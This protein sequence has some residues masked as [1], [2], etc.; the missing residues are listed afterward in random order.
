MSILSFLR[1]IQGI[2]SRGGKPA[3]PRNRRLELEPLEWRAVLTVLET[4]LP[5]LDSPEV[6]STVLESPP[7][8][9]PPPSPEDDGG[10]GSGTGEPDPGQAPDP[11]GESLPMDGGSGG[12]NGDPPPDPPLTSGSGSG[13]GTGSEA[14][15]ITSLESSH[16]GWW[17]SFSGSVT[18]ADGPVAGLIVYFTIGEETGVAFT[19]I[20][21]AD[22]TFQTL[23]LEIAANTLINAYTIDAEGNQSSIATCYA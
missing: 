9:D 19:A 4:P 16:T 14:P 7:L 20:V 23:D 3:P 18:D 12:G 21:Q 1:V 10:S 2:Q 6:T 22:G 17:V 5:I 15:I 13:T 11:S 8:G